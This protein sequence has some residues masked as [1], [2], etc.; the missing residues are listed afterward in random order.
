MT[1]S[2]DDVRYL[3]ADMIGT[4]AFLENAINWRVQSKRRDKLNHCVFLAAA[5][6]ADGDILD[7]I[8]ER[9]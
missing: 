9:A 2:R 8:V 7:R 5:Q 6:E 1:D 4:S 3:V